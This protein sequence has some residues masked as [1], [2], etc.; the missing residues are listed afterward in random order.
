MILYGASGHAKVIASV[1][2]DNNIPL[3]LFFDDD[4]MKSVF[5]GIKVLRY[6]A[7]IN[8]DEPLIISIGSN[9][10]RKKVSEAIKHNFEKVIHPSS[11]IASNVAIGKG[12]VVLHAATIQTDTKIGK[13]C[14]INTSACIDHECDIANFVHISPNSTLC[15]NVKV[16]EGTQIGA[17]AIILP[18]ITI[19]KWSIIGAGAVITKDVPDN[20]II[21]GNPG[22]ILK[23]NNNE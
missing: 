23:K 14:I 9:V 2:N 1:L 7:E 21:V 16:G 5:I 10:L 18:N 11:L 19:G 20:V 8:H 12:T 22:K 13:H 17:G 3:S 15:G 4:L 6:S